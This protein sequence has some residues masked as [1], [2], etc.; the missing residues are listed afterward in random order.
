M[1]EPA[2]SLIILAGGDSRRFGSTKALAEWRGKRLVDHVVERIGQ[3]GDATILVTNPLPEDPAWPGDKVVYDDQ[4]QPAGPLRGIVRG[5]A[6]CTADW[7]W[8]VACDTP[9]VSAELLL[10]LRREAKPGDVAV[11]PMWQERRQPLVACWE[12]AAGPALAE[13]L[14]SGEHSPGAALERF[15]CRA[16]PEE[17][18]RKVDPDGRSFFNVNR[19]EEL[20]E[21]DRLFPG[22][23]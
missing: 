14:A 20:A 13:L 8:V 21:L 12:K 10:A 9:L 22:N 3:I 23:E 16:F 1:A 7:A 11:A 15:G 17:R 19:P 2:T 6:E 18:C 4:S 5:L